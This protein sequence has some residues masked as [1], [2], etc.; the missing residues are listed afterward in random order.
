MCFLFFHKYGKVEEGYQYCL[1]CGKA[2]IAPQQH[3]HKWFLRTEISLVDGWSREP[4]GHIF[5]YECENCGE[6]KKVKT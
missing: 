1:K 6:V 2:I 3:I 5:L 4:C